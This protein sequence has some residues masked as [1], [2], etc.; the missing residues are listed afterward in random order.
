MVIPN[1]LDAFQPK[2]GRKTQEHAAAISATGNYCTCQLIL[3]F[4]LG[5]CGVDASNV[6]DVLTQL[7][8]SVLR[9]LQVLVFAS[10]RY[11]MTVG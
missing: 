7:S 1:I 6:V 5:E 11:T 3:H 9:L 4:F 8:V 2:Y 10:A